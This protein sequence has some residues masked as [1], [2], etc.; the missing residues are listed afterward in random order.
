M[1]TRAKIQPINFFN[2]IPGKN[3]KITFKAL[4]EKLYVSFVTMLK[5]YEV[6]TLIKNLTKDENLE[7][8]QA[9]FLDLLKKAQDSNHDNSSIL[10][11]G[12]SLKASD[13]NNPV[14]NQDFS[15]VANKNPPIDPPKRVIIDNKTGI[16]LIKDEYVSAVFKT[17]S[18]KI[19]PGKWSFEYFRE[20]LIHAQSV[21]NKES[22]FI[23]IQNFEVSRSQS[24]RVFEALDKNNLGFLYAYTLFTVIDAYSPR[25]L[26]KLPFF[27]NENMVGNILVLME[28]YLNSKNVTDPFF[29][30][31]PDIVSTIEPLFFDVFRSDADKIKSCFHVESPVYHWVATLES[32]CKHPA[33]SGIGILRTFLTLNQTPVANPD[34]SSRYFST[35]EEL[36][37]FLSEKCKF[38]EAESECIIKD[39]YGKDKIIWPLYNFYSLVEYVDAYKHQENIVM[40]PYSYSK[41]N[42]DVLNFFRNL[43]SVFSKPISYYSIDIN[44]ETTVYELNNALETFLGKGNYSHINMLDYKKNS[45]IKI[46]AFISVLDSFRPF[47]SN[48]K[49]DPDPILNM[50]KSPPL[51]KEFEQS[52]N[53]IKKNKLYTKE[54]V[55]KLNVPKSIIDDF[56]YFLNPLKPKENPVYGYQ[57][58]CL[59]QI[60]KLYNSDFKDFPVFTNYN[61]DDRIFKTLKEFANYIDTNQ[62]KTINI[63]NIGPDDRLTLD[64]FMNYKK[65]KENT[66]Q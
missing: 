22:L 26:P 1:I 51:P 32:Y 2:S 43:S 52:I 5:K 63:L 65:F 42:P 16:S 48:F 24:D 47:P 25:S 7:I 34:E 36:Y 46:F 55:L 50:F 64:L 57:L 58:F 13:L 28:R 56:F 20:N 19:N 6:D 3:G 38:S 45:K 62:I 35:K 40:L 33:I 54:E 41:Q 14:A 39:A 15:Q 59:F 27:W 66:D 53:N 23:V 31:Y 60:N 29:Y 12:N 37:M 4:K 10:D 18:S 9:E 30:D 11:Y 21:L 8:S 44:I 61:C 17:I 49:H